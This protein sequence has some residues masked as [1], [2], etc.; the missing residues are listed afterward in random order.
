MYKRQVLIALEQGGYS[1]GGEQSGHLIYP[2][3]ATTGDG[4]LAGLV[5]AELVRRSRRPLAELAGEVLVAYPQVLQNVRTGRLP[6]GVAIGELLSEEIAAAEAELGTDGRVLVRASGTEALVRVMVE[7]PT[8]E[9]AES[10]AAHL[11]N[12]VAAKLA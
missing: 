10:T 1:L 7:A 3:L 4:L 12:A 8:R 5:V 2:S 11:S 9:L 6:A